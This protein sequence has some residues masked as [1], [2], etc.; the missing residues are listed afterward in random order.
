MYVVLSKRVACALIQE[1]VMRSCSNFKTIKN[2]TN[3]IERST[4]SANKLHFTVS[5]D[6]SDHILAANRSATNHLTTQ[7]HSASSR[8]SS[9]Y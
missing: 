5:K 6:H 8:S 2:V 7:D 4:E 3:G 1:D 9:K